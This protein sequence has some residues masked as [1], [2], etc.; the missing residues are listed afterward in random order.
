MA[1]INYAEGAAEDNSRH[2][3]YFD[4]VDRVLKDQG[5][6]FAV[7]GWIT[8]TA[9]GVHVNSFIQAPATSGNAPFEQVVSLPKAMGGG[10]LTA[11]L[12]PDRIT[13]QSVDL[14]AED[15]KNI[16]WA[17]GES[18]KLRKEPNVQSPPITV[19]TKDKSFKVVGS[20]GTWIRLQAEDGASGWTSA[21]EFCVDRC[22]DLLDTARFANDIV[23]LADGAPQAPVS[24]KLTDEARSFSDQLA[25]LMALGRDPARAT[26]ILAGPA[27]GPTTPDDQVKDAL[28]PWTSGRANLLAVAQVAAALEEARRNQPRFD[29]IRLPPE[30]IRNIANTLAAGV[31][32]R[33]DRS[34]HSGQSRGSVRVSRRSRATQSRLADRGGDAVP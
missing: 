27:A 14:N 13:L 19:L 15:A 18:A 6:P 9:D 21:D 1:V 31:G 5:F 25:A 16:G 24:T 34:H 20:Q 30:L 17:A 11:G 32:R 29:N 23:A 33:P 7:W 8:R 2:V 26:E 10:R 12:K 22:S 4:K 3:A 28:G